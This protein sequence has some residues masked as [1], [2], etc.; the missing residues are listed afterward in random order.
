LQLWGSLAIGARRPH[1]QNAKVENTHTRLPDSM[2]AGVATPFHLER[3]MG[4]HSIGGISRQMRSIALL[5][6]TF[7]DTLS[8]VL[9]DQA[10]KT[11][12]RGYREEECLHRGAESSDCKTLISGH[13]GTRSALP[14]Y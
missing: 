4:N 2:W 10:C 13:R 11:K 6:R 8:T 12:H 14:L 3:I 1:G 7:F 9:L 5:T